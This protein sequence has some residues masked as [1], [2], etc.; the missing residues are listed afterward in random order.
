MATR[1]LIG[2]VN[3]DGSISAIY[4]HFDGYPQGVGV[5]LALN[6]GEK[7]AKRLI[8]LGNRSSLFSYP[9]KK[10]AY[11]YPVS[12][13]KMNLGAEDDART[14][15]D[16]KE[17]A[18]EAVQTDV[19]YVY[20]GQQLPGYGFAW[21]AY[22]VE[23]GPSHDIAKGIIDKSLKRLGVIRPEVKFERHALPDLIS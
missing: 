23:Y 7:Q 9:T 4:N 2:I 20:I 3:K 18:E 19:R 6:Y 5:Q 15:K 17:F 21:E 8:Q 10:G 16:F 22:S 1:S 13:I 14:Y 12:G 11:K